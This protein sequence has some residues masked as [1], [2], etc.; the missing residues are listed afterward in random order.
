MRHTN[1]QNSTFLLVISIIAF[2]IIVITSCDPAISYRYTINNKS[3][4]ELKVYFQV[5]N[6]DSTT[7]IQ[8]RTKVD[9][10]EIGAWGSNPH[11]EKDNF[12]NVTFDSINIEAVDKTKLEVDFRKRDNWI[13][14]VDPGK[15]LLINVGQ[16]IYELEINNEDFSQ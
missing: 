4:K 1:F 5:R 9:I 6:S 3:D 14:E 11:D 13:Y 16:N 2:I 12:L 15:M 8:P 10:L 7:F